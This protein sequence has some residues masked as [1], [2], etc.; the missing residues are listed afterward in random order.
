ME[1]PYSRS[2]TTASIH[3]QWLMK[4]SQCPLPESRTGLVRVSGWHTMAPSR[5]GGIT[6]DTNL[7]ASKSRGGKLKPWEQCKRA[8]VLGPTAL[9]VWGI[10]PQRACCL[11]VHTASWMRKPYSSIGL[12]VQMSFF[13]HLWQVTSGIS[14][15]FLRFIYLF[16][17][18]M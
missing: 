5:V 13:L 7:E 18:Y 14:F 15:F 4:D 6:R 16:I 10:A 1:I 12:S 8:R 2:H 9:P 11:R 17:Y 3:I